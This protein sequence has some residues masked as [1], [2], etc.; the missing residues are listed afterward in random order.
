MAKLK[1]GRH[2]SALK[3]ARKNETNYSA[4]KSML[5]SIRTLSRQ[6]EEAISS[7]NT[8]SARS[9]INQTYSMWDK[10]AKKNIVHWK[11]AARTKSRL[12]LK[13]QALLKSGEFQ[14]EN[15]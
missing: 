6:L 3:E 10:A 12:S 1:T 9:L 15:A 13:L 8:Q 11:K 5:S 14:N 7:G 2:T 4:N